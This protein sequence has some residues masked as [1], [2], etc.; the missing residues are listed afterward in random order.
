MLKQFYM[1]TTF[2]TVFQSRVCFFNSQSSDSA[3]ILLESPELEL[4]LDI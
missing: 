3:D 4:N 1:P 2:K